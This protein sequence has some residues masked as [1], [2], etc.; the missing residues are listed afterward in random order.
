MSDFP[1]STS[2]SQFPHRAAGPSPVARDYTLRMRL[3][4][5][6]VG[7]DAKIRA[8]C[9]L[10]AGGG[11]TARGL[12]KDQFCEP[13]SPVCWYRLSPW[14][15]RVSR[16]SWVSGVNTGH[17]KRGAP[18]TSR[19]TRSPRD[20]FFR[21]GGR[22][23]TLVDVSGNANLPVGEVRGA[24]QG[25]GVKGCRP[26]DSPRKRARSGQFF[27]E[28]KELAGSRTFGYDQDYH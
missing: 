28:P 7:R 22:E 8:M 27:R 24:V 5:M 10:I 25:G 17:E 20:A 4:A 19:K 15:S 23:P 6:T 9:G 2:T 16:V 13:V 18:S 21:R 26:F 3:T 12:L 1:K 11:R 14:V